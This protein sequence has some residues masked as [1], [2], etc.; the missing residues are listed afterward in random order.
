MDPLVSTR[1]AVNALRL[2]I[3][4]VSSRFIVDAQPG[5]E[6]RRTVLA[7]RFAVSIFVFGFSQI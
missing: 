4:A 1:L 7:G 2:V 5:L 3:V 6:R